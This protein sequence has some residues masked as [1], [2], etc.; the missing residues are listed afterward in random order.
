MFLVS[1]SSCLCA[2]YWNQVL[3][4][5]WRCSWSSADRRCSNYI[6]VINNYIAYWGASYIW[7]LTVLFFSTLDVTLD[8]F[9]RWPWFHPC[10]S[11]LHRC[12]FRR[13][14]W[15]GSRYELSVTM[16]VLAVFQYDRDMWWQKMTRVTVL[17]RSLDVSV[18]LSLAK[19]QAV[20]HG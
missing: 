17:A 7:G 6:W 9:C 13:N 14:G 20:T 4:R 18:W 5:E 16:N 19:Y 10:I 1:F 15:M 8:D 12:M 11:R 3:G 2:I